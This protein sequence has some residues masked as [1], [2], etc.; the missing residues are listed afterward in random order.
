MYTKSKLMLTALT[1]LAFTASVP[2]ATQIKLTRGGDDVAPPPTCDDHGVDGYCGSIAQNGADDLLELL[3][4]HG[5]DV[6]VR[7]AEKGA[8]DGQADDHGDDFIT[9]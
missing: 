3:D 5:L 6:I 1:A 4:D 9:G 8:D 7:V 2:A